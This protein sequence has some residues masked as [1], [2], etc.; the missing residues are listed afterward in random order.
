MSIN[1]DSPS[2]YRPPIYWANTG[3]FCLQSTTAILGFLKEETGCLL[4]LQFFCWFFLLRVSQHSGGQWL[5]RAQFYVQNMFF[6]NPSVWIRELKYSICKLKKK[7]QNMC[8]LLFFYF[9]R[10]LILKQDCHL[11][12]PTMLRIIKLLS[13]LLLTSGLF[14]REISRTNLVNTILTR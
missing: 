1:P 14:D 13:W 11:P 8:M 2:I 5:Y 10:S 7:I 4:Y 12:H 9:N 3:R 6:F